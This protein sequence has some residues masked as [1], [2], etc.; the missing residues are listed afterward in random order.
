[1]KK[2][3]KQLLREGLNDIAGFSNITPEEHKEI[4]RRFNDYMEEDEDSIIK[5]QKRLN[6]IYAHIEQIQNNQN[7]E[8]HIKDMVV[9]QISDEINV[10]E[11]SI[12]SSKNRDKKAVYDFIARNYLAHKRHEE[13]RIKARES[14]SFGKEDIVNLF[15]TALE[16]GSNYW[17]KIKHLPKEIVYKIN[18]LGIP[19]AEVIGQH[20]LNGGYIQFYDVEEEDNEDDDYQQQYSDKDL[21]GT[22]DMDAILEG[23][24]LV[25]KDYPEVWENILDEQYDA[26]DADVFL[27]LCVMGE[28]VFG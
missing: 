6:N 12:K 23:I 22:V 9:K 28:V 24:T 5:N 26:N 19:T 27:Q 17:Y 14:K 1:M 15:V 16:G 20:I 8:Q 3:I 25:K 10:L 13:D 4:D 2:I 11:T 7:L 18:E 21:L